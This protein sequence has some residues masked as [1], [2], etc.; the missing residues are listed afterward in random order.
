YKKRQTPLSE[1]QFERCICGRGY[2]NSNAF[3]LFGRLPYAPS[4]QPRLSADLT[5]SALVA[6]DARDPLLRNKSAT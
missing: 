1:V 2:A 5:R 4:L 6:G 3:L